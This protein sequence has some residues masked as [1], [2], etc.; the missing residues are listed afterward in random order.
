MDT[1][2]KPEVKIEQPS[3]GVRFHCSKCRHEQRLYTPGHSGREAELLRLLMTGSPLVY[4]HAPGADSPIGKSEC[5]R[6]QLEGEL[7]GYGLIVIDS[8]RGIV[9]IE[10]A[11]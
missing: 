4:P 3:R 7:F 9:E 2:D 6:A 11:P 10:A 1:T 5:C 8:E